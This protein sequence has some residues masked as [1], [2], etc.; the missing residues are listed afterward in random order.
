M[1]LKYIETIKSMILALTHCFKYHIYIFH[2]DVYTK[3]PETIEETSTV[4]ISIGEKER[5]L[6]KLLNLI[7]PLFNFE[8]SL[9][10]TTDS[11]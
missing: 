8:E 5:R 2:L 1:G 6:K 11:E 9:K 10:G 7:K 4:D 3:I